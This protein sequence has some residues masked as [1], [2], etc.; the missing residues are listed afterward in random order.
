MPFGLCNA[1]ATFQRLV[2]SLFDKYIGHG[3]GV[4]ID[5]I[6]IYEDSAEK[7]DDLLDMVLRA[8]IRNGLFLNIKKS[9]FGYRRVRY[10]GMIVDGSGIHPDPAKVALVSRL[11]PPEDVIGLRRFLGTIGYFRQFIKRFTSRA[12]ALTQLL[13]RGIS[14]NSTQEQQAAFEDLRS[15]LAKNQS[16]YHFL[17]LVGLG[18]STPMRVAPKLRQFCSKWIHSTGHT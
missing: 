14:W 3:V 7:H 15:V 18:S 17:T 9:M 4:Y 6:V 2:D 11:Q 5:D 12:E 16:Y 8:L 10:L 13:R 1:P